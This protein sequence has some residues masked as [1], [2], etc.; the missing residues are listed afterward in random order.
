MTLDYQTIKNWPIA[1]VSKRYSRD[2]VI[3]F[4]GGFGAGLPGPLREEDAPFIQP[5]G[6]RALPMVAVALADGEFWQMNPAAGLQW[7]KTVHVEEAITV[8]KPLAVEGGL[9]VKRRIEAVYD[10]GAER[11][12]LVQERQTLIDDSNEPVA[13][14]DVATLL[15]GDGG[16]GGEPEPQRPR[17]VFPDRPPDHAVELATPLTE[18]AVFRLSGSLDVAAGDGAMLRGVCSFGLAGRAVLALCCGNRPERLLKFGV[19]YAGPMFTEET[20]RI[21]LWRIA[22]GQAV[23]RMRA[24]ERDVLVLNNC[25]VEYVE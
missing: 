7:Q 18:N 17:I 15:R 6:L 12:A 10:R 9:T 25:T 23:F 5:E 14:I 21:E 1:P 16:F 4:A 3:R 2:D 20:M 19:R 11:G 13:T 8:H 22:T 24:V